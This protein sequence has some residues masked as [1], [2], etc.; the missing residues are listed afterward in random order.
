MISYT[1]HDLQRLLGVKP[2][3]IRYWEK[4]IPLLQP[5]KEPNGRRSYSNRDI[6]LFLRLKYLLYDRRFT[7]EGAREQLFRELSGENQDI[8]AIIAAL[9]TELAD[10]FFLL[11]NQEKNG[12][13][14]EAE[15]KK[16]SEKR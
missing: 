7:V 5:K 3:I 14:N 11:A 1:L 8:R 16:K 12:I 13:L 6:Q 2:Y 10:L 15:K 4:E 9:R